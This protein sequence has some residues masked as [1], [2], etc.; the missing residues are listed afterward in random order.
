MTVTSE[1]GD[2]TSVSAT[3][4]TAYSL[5]LSDQVT[6]ITY[7][8]GDTLTVGPTEAYGTNLAPLSA[9]ATAT[10]TSGN[11]TLAINGLQSATAGL[12]LGR[13]G[14][15]PEPDRRLWPGPATINRIVV[16]T[17]SLGSTAPGVRNY[18]VSVDQPGT[19]WTT[20]ATVVGQYRNHELQLAFNP[21]T[22]SAVR[23]TVSE[24]NFGG[25]YGGGIPPLWPST[26]I[27]TAFLHALQVYA[28]TGT[29]AQV[30]GTGLTPL[31]TGNGQT[32]TPPDRPRPPRYRRAAAEAEVRGGG[33]SPPAAGPAVR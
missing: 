6:Y 25:Y 27:E 16:D 3:S 22:A 14:R 33:G 17:Q 31:T 11:A 24:V 18:T 26:Q 32:P 1:Y 29:P 7:P 10:A 21:V 5:P 28:G 23:I 9:G 20:V 2:T 15:H 19:G 12:G 13:R 4:G 8:V 30:D